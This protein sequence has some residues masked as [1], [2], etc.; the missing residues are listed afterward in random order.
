MVFVKM[1]TVRAKSARE[2]DLADS[3]NRFGAAF[4]GQ[5]GLVDCY[6]FKERGT[7]KLV[8]ISVWDTEDPFRKAML[9]VRPTP[10]KYLP[11]TLPDKPPSIQRFEQL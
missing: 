4:R 1:A 5:R 11:D 6:V 7:G 2:G 10:P 8:G 3:M 9:A